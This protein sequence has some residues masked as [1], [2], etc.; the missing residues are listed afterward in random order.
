[1]QAR[2]GTLELK[3]MSVEI[4]QATLQKETRMKKNG[5]SLRPVLHQQGCNMHKWKSQSKGKR[6]SIE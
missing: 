6:R 4:I 1:M 3:D 5:Q 2:E